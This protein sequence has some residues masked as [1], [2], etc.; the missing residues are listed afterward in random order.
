MKDKITTHPRFIRKLENDLEILYANGDYDSFLERFNEYEI[1]TSDNNLDIIEMFYHILISKKDYESMYQYAEKNFQMKEMTR[2]EAEIHFNMILQSLFN[3]GVYEVLLE[4]SEII[5]ATGE[6]SGITPSLLKFAKHCKDYAAK[7]I[8]NEIQSEDISQTSSEDI[9]I[10]K[11]LN[12]S[13]KALVITALEY[14]I[15][16]KDDSYG[17]D[18]YSL[19]KKETTLSVSSMMIIYLKEIEYDAVIEINKFGETFKHHTSEFKSF[20]T[21]AK[22]SQTIKW[23]VEDGN[24]RLDNEERIEQAI[25]MFLNISILWYPLKVPFTPKEL[26]K[27]FISYTKVLNNELSV[28][29]FYGHV[30]EWILKI[31]DGIRN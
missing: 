1:V 18:V 9:D 8:A 14:L 13:N 15:D 28:Q 19:L 26:A 30:A 12:S 24:I 16:K 4:W 17:Q 31:E 27:G 29:S 11:S 6:N 7:Q 2:E 10:D 25:E 22:I 3:L 23:I 21:S 5:V 20:E